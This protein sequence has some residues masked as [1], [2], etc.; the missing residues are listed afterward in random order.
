MTKFVF[1]KKFAN[2]FDQKWSQKVFQIALLGCKSS[3]FVN[4]DI[5]LQ[6]MQPGIFDM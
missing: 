1:L 3:N 5:W 4:F 2:F 6:T